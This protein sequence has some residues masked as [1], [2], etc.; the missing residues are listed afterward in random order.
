MYQYIQ[1][2]IYYNIFFSECSEAEITL[3]KREIFDIIKPHLS[4]S[5]DKILQLIENEINSRQGETFE[6]TQSVK[7]KLRVVLTKMRQK[8]IEAS[9]TESRFME[10]NADWLDTTVVIREKAADSVEVPEVKNPGKLNNNF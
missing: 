2:Y 10:W 6:I 8:Y 4:N 7:K 5:N 9:R 1:T 3:K